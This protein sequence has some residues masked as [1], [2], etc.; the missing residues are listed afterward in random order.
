MTDHELL[1]AVA[2]VLPG[3]THFDRAVYAYARL[4]LMRGEALKPEQR[5]VLQRVLEEGRRENYE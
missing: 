1:T 5:A 4:R 2:S 3:L